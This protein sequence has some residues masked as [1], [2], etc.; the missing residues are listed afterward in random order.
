MET[1]SIT[2]FRWCKSASRRTQFIVGSS[3]DGFFDSP[4]TTWRYLEVRKQSSQ[5]SHQ[6]DSEDSSQASGDFFTHSWLT[7]L[8]LQCLLHFWGL[9]ESF[10]EILF[11]NLRG[12]PQPPLFWAC[13]LCCLQ[14]FMNNKL[15]FVPQQTI[16]IKTSWMTFY[17]PLSP[18]ERFQVQECL[19]KPSKTQEK[20]QFGLGFEF[21]GSK[22][23]HHA[24]WHPLHIIFGGRR[25]VLGSS[26]MQLAESKKN[27]KMSIRVDSRVTS[28][29]VVLHIIFVGG[30]S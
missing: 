25:S 14:N 10:Y 12:K 13:I 11:I 22:W 17:L 27:N 29:F 7:L 3:T 8:V 4:T 2:N 16:S 20:V 24:N 23:R 9:F 15:K 1:A 21:S 18:R 5:T 28:S 30:E 26:L 19:S 6:H